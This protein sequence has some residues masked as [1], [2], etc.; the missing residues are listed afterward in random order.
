LIRENERLV[1]NAMPLHNG[2]MLI[3]QNTGFPRHAAATITRASSQF[4][5]V[6]VT[7]ARQVGKTSLLRHLA[8]PERGY[9]TLD[10]PLQLRLAQQDPALFLQTH[11]APVLIDEVQ[12]A[13]QLLPHLKMAADVG[14]RPGD[15]WLTGSQPFHLMQGVSESLAG[16]VA[17]LSLLGLSRRESLRLPAP[18]PFAPSPTWYTAM[19]SGLGG[20][21]NVRAAPADDL[22]TI[23]HR[24]WRG[25]YPALAAQPEM[26]RDIFYSS[27][28]QT[29]LQRD[30]RDLANVG[31]LTSFLRFIRAA[32]AR[33]G[34]LLNIADL[35][36]DADVSPNT[37]KHW[38]AVLEAS[39]I[40]HLVQPWHVN[41]TLRLVK[42][43]KLYFNDTGLVAWLTQWSSPQ[44]LE[45][46]AMAGA[47]F[48]TWVVAEIIKSRL[49]VGL[50]EPLFYFRNKDQR[51]VDLLIQ[52]NGLLHPVEI[53]KTANPGADA[54]AGIKSLHNLGVPLG[55]GAVVCMVQQ[56]IPLLSQPQ[57]IA[58]PAGLL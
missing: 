29:Y 36:R 26:D 17:V 27:Y 46:G 5:V 18:P 53:K 33:T 38:L 4:K 25:S 40:V 56:P 37:G 12:Y 45:A 9:V 14:G 34:Q 28:V 54:L 15:W 2:R 19:L 1:Q 8:G 10:D 44:T 52:S 35:A 39:G 13:P 11:R 24:I 57:V 47:I 51:E 41:L 49:N 55:A 30:V 58:W 42:R 50:Q 22:S 16:R 23:F 7:G 32:A 43:P 20:Q 48:E 21:A 6:L 31:N 3:S